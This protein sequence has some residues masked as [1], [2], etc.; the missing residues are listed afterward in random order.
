MIFTPTDIAGATIIDIEPL[1]DARGFFAR[2]WCQRELAAQG[3]CTDIAQESISYNRDAAT[4]R[5]LHFQRPPHGEVK[6]V[7]C[8][9][10]AIQDVIVDIRPDSPTF[11][12]WQGFELT[13]A[14]HRALYVPNGCAHGFLT[15]ADETEV[16]YLISTFYVPAASAGYRYNDPAF[17]IVWPLPVKV[18]S[19]RDLQWPDFEPDPALTG[20]LSS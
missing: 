12:R 11:R 15:L 10:G 5:G 7:R 14:N 20:L 9:H 1:R 6:I 4:M 2:S 8:V 3:L 17:G 13:A 18:I 19:E 16:A